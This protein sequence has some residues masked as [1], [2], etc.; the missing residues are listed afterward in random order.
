[1]TQSSRKCELHCFCMFICVCFRV[2]GAQQKSCD[3]SLNSRWLP[4]TLA[5]KLRVF[6][7]SVAVSLHHPTLSYN[8][9]AT[10]Y[11]T[12]SSDGVALPC[13]SI[14]QPLPRC[15]AAICV[16]LN[17]VVCTCSGRREPFPNKTPT[18]STAS[19]WAGNQHILRHCK[20]KQLARLAQ[21]NVN[22]SPYWS[23]TYKHS[24]GGHYITC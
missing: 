24:R 16:K 1:M 10:V 19:D 5:P 8:K 11:S 9:A 3:P 14:L 12:C 21:L 20:P 17:K 23:F 18:L 22:L 6:T 2:K 15:C 13:R 7:H 4:D